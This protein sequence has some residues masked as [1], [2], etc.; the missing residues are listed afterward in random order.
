M[1]MNHHEDLASSIA[2]ELSPDERL[3]WTGRPRQGVFF[4]R[5]G[6]AFAIPLTTFWCGLSILVGTKMFSTFG[7]NNRAP[8]PILL[9]CV[10]AMLFGLYMMI[11][12][13]FV[14]SR[15]R[16]KTV[17]AVTSKRIIIRSGLFKQTTDSL[18][19]R[20]LPTVSQDRHAGGRG[21]IVFGPTDP[22]M[23]FGDFGGWPGFRGR[24][25]PPRFESIEEAAR[26]CEIIHVAQGPV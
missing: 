22:E 13:F 17:Y 2:P 3:L 24:L 9:C 14:D 19:L 12:R 8:W 1:D 4:L 10:L 16:A 23:L 18:S 26:V 21:T 15:Q 7:G 6:D 5:A 20:D 25:R 11:G